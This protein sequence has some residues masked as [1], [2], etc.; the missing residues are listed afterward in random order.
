MV[1]YVLSIH[2]LDGEVEQQQTTEHVAATFDSDI[3]EALHRMEKRGD[4][5]R[6]A[7]DVKVE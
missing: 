7:V 2:Y 6:V 1:T 4:V 3:F 5:V